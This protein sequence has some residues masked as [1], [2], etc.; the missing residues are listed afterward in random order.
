MNNHMEV[1]MAAFTVLIVAIL[2]AP[3]IVFVAD[4]FSETETGQKIIS[5]IVGEE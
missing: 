5:K 1:K 2:A 4:L 3:L